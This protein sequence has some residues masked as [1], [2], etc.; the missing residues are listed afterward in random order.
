MRKQMTNTA[1]INNS[2]SGEHLKEWIMS[3]VALLLFTG[4]CPSRCALYAA[5]GAQT[6]L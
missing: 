2:I 3:D 5:G 1:K 4:R 6:R